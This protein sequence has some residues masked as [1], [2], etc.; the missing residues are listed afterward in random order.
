MLD[1]ST[2][3]ITGS[4]GGIGRSIIKTF[5]ENKC[6][7][8]AC[9]RKP[10]KDFEEEC[11]SL[12]KNYKNKIKFYYFDLLDSEST[13]NNLKLIIS[14]NKKIDILINNA[15]SIYTNLFQ[16]TSEKTFK[17]IFQV[18]FF[19]QVI[20]MQ[21]VLKNMLK[22]KKG[23]IINIS[24]SAAYENNEGRSAYASAKSS[25]I[26][27]SKVLAKEVG[28]KNIR[29]NVVSP[30]L[31]NTSMLRDSSTQNFINEKI[32]QISLKRIAEPTEIS[33]VIL[34]LASDLSSYVTGEVIKVDGG[35]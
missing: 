23:S 27:L 4:G 11:K 26:T 2:A 3:L 21:M 19:S 15:G 9:L 1:N 35:L 34:F 13:L 32:D 30:G 24:S 33:K 31:T 14:E 7:I 28:K 29:V 25:I 6:N 8:I 12:E 18:N 17:E 20:I 22:E 16:M 10:N 5:S